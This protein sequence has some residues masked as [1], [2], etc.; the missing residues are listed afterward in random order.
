[1]SAAVTDLTGAPADERALATAIR[2]R[3]GAPPELSW[4]RVSVV[5]LNRDGA[6]LL[7]RLA[8][9]LVEQTDYPDLELILVDN[10][11]TDDS[12]D[13]IR[14]AEVPFPISILANA[15]NESFSHACNQG[16][17]LASG[18]L[19]LFLNNDVELFEPGWLRELVACL[20]AQP[21][22]GA[23]APTLL[24]PAAGSSSGYRV[25]QRGLRTRDKAGVL[26]P[27]FRD[28]H[29]D[30]LGSGLGVNVESAALAA[31]CLLID[32]AD[33]ESVE[34]FTSGYWYGPEDV[35]LALKLRDRGLSSASSGRSL[36]IHPPGS[37]L[38]TVD[39]EQR[40][41]WIEGNRRL[42]LERW[43]PRLR[44]EY[45]LDRLAGTGVWA[46][47]DDGDSI[48]ASATRAELEA[49]GFCL[50]ASGFGAAAGPAGELV[51]LADALRARGYRCLVARNAAVGDLAPL[52]Y[53]IAVYLRGPQRYVPRPAQ[54]NVLWC[55]GRLDELSGIECS[56][57]DLVL[58]PTSRGASSL[59]A[60]L[61]EA[62][63]T[64]AAEIGFRTRI[65][66]P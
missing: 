8:T 52:E 51:E 40:L 47:P 23:V 17:E 10:A 5:V 58:S 15:H 36:V 43:G 55:V 26:V 28:H 13:F 12:L 33:F 18:E 59:A 38:K 54:L 39:R 30:P 19:L 1:M 22:V 20:L 50:Q 34:G 45:E 46:E 14:S 2:R 9:G 3:L 21:D 25:H 49:F 41:A 7:R 44:R 11:S 4:P 65:G 61:L 42:F 32:R 35:D 27:A 24:E 60:E 31:A 63:Q 6:P 66:E 64:R 37:T 16:A 62:V 57:Y 56:T 53:D 29:M 48:P